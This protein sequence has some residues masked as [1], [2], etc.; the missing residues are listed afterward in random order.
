MAAII[1]ASIPPA[2]SASAKDDVA[3]D[4]VML[5]ALNDAL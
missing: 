5:R 4:V 1:A 3:L 2:D